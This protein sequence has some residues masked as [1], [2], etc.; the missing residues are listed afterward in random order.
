MTELVRYQIETRHPVTGYWK[1][2]RECM[3][4]YE[5]ERYMGRFFGFLWKTLKS[6]IINKDEAELWCRKEVMMCRRSY[7]K[8][9]KDVRV[10]IT[11]LI[12][13]HVYESVIWENGVWKDC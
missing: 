10:T 1:V 8:E 9:F 11:A 4:H 6:R 5:R 7:E 2:Q 13:G 3:C 12:D